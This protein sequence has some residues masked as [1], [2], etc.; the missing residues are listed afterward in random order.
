[1]WLTDTSSLIDLLEERP[2]AIA[3][4]D[5][6]GAEGLYSTSNVITKVQ[7]NKRSAFRDFRWDKQQQVS[8]FSENVLLGRFPIDF[9]R[10]EQFFPH[11]DP[12]SFLFSLGKRLQVDG[13]H[14]EKVFLPR[15]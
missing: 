13:G 6:L 3:L 5:Q 7:N 15:S 1:M 11:S 12:L 14:N 9:Y 4:Y 2:E 10:L 8:L